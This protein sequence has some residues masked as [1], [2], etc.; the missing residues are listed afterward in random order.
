ML[1]LESL[2]NLNYP[3]CILSSKKAD[4][5]NG[6]IV[7]TVFQLIPEPPA[8]AVSIN[9]QNLTC[10]FINQSKI[11]AVSILSEDTP[12]E[13]IRQ[14]GFKSGRDLNKFELLKYKIGQT[15]APIVMENTVSFIEARVVNTVDLHTHTLFI[16]NITE[17]GII[18]DKKIPMAYTY[19]R[20]V[21][22]GK[23][24]RSAA[25]Y[26]EKKKK[27]ESKQGVVTMKK[28]KCLMCG[29]IYNPAEGDPENNI[30]PGTAFED[31]PDDWTC[32]DCGVG[33]DEFKPIED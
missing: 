1:D 30:E 6:C 14:F 23:T 18:D 5:I 33:K 10:E 16:G 25:T 17:C 12:I 4:Q 27:T 13:L 32:P 7:N 8:L 22:H 29:Y 31:I 11:F 26:I 19:Y 15:G 9:N 20:D 2:F 24:P 28:Y 3:M 21:K